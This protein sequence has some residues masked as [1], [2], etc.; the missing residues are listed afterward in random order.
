M[1]SNDEKMSLMFCSGSSEE[2]GMREEEG[3]RMD[4]LAEKWLGL[5]SRCCC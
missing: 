3:E 5:R 2:T 4:E 1:N